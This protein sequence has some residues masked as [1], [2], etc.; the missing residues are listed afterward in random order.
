MDGLERALTRGGRLAFED[1]DL[2]SYLGGEWPCFDQEVSKTAAYLD[3]VEGLG[4]GFAPSLY[5]HEKVAYRLVL[6]ASDPSLLDFT[7]VFPTGASLFDDLYECYL[8]PPLDEW[9]D[10]GAYGRV[11]AATRRIDDAAARDIT[12]A[13]Y[14]SAGPARTSTFQ[15]RFNLR[16]FERVRRWGVSDLRELDER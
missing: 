4:S 3:R 2:A 7:R 12:R 11:G 15:R 14:A 13:V 8:V 10:L 16:Y 5:C 1:R 6:N 9:F